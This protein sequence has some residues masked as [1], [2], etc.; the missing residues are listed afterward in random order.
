MRDEIERLKSQIAGNSKTVLVKEL[1]SAN[2]KANENQN[3]IQKD[4]SC[5]CGRLD[6]EPNKIAIQNEI[7]QVYDDI[8]QLEQSLIELD[9]QNTQNA[10]EVC[11]KRSKQGKQ[12]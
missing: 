10:I 1:E 9:E 2:K 6:D 8:M 4:I 5:S 12:S 3:K 7:S 11:I